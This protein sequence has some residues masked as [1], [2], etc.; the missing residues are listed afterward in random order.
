MKSI[1]KLL[2]I[3]AGL[4]PMAGHAFTPEF[5]LPAQL[6]VSETSDLSSFN[7]VTGA[8]VDGE[9]PAVVLEGGV[10]KQA[11][12][13]PSSELTSLQILDPL[14]QQLE[15]EEFSL[16]Y[17]C[18]TDACGGFDFRFAADV[19]PE[20]G[21][22]IDLND[23]RFLS[24]RRT[25]DAGISEALTIMISRTNDTGFVQINQL[26]AAGSIAISS[27]EAGTIA[28]IISPVISSDLGQSLETVGH[29]VLDAVQFRSG[30]AELAQ[31]GMSTLGALADY[32]KQN[33][34]RQV[35]LVG[36]TDAV[37]SLDAN[38]AL[39]KRR[40]RSV[41]QY[42]TQELGVSASQVAAEGVGYLAPRASNLT[43][44]GREANRRVEVTLTSTE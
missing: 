13:L 39:S 30:G 29:A 26:G 43:D 4:F 20:P 8:W 7:L 11:W 35:T 15:N 10:S 18:D 37:G 31:S 9:V 25:S 2:L 22:H 17:E 38:I 42:L 19:F 27:G 5:P 16:V 14:R 34:A 41:M 32:L 23:F 44:A 12:R 28:P 33:P 3:C 1:P 24:A 6:S 21:M 40:A 36:H